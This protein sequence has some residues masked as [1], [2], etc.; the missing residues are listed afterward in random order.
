MMLLNIVPGTNNSEKHI[1]PHM[2]KNCSWYKKNP[3]HAKVNGLNFIANC[4]GKKRYN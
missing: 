3:K 1:P 4:Y 2:R